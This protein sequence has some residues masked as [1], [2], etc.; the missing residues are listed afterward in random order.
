MI[1]LILSGYSNFNMVFVDI[2]LIISAGMVYYLFDK[3][4]SDGFKIGAGFFL[5]VSG[6]VRALFALFSINQ[7]EDNIAL[8]LF[9]AMLSLEIMVILIAKKMSLK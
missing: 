9:I 7:L 2:S 5:V 8:I 3:V 6:L 4:V 1:G